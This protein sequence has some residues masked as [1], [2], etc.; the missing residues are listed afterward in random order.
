VC[1]LTGAIHVR[2]ERWDRLETKEHRPADGVMRE[3]GVARK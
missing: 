3:G 2:S 1:P